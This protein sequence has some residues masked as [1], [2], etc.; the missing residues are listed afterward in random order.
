[1]E[2]D[3]RVQAIQNHLNFCVRLITANA[4][5]AWWLSTDAPASEDLIAT[6]I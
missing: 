6:M 2:N 5:H 4:G 3:S 1:V